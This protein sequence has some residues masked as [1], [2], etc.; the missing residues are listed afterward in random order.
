MTKAGSDSYLVTTHC[1]LSHYDYAHYFITGRGGF[2]SA[3]LYNRLVPTGG[4]GLKPGSFVCQVL[5]EAFI[6][7]WSVYVTTDGSGV[8]PAPPRALSYGCALPV[9]ESG[10][11]PLLHS[12]HAHPL[13]YL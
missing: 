9:V 2:L 11:M 12:S 4:V 5:P 8:S 6:V 13:E 7:R 10:E 1:R 3:T